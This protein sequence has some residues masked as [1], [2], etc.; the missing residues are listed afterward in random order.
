VAK[1][2]AKK[3]RVAVI[4]NE[5]YLEDD[6]GRT[7][8]WLTTTKPEGQPEL[9]FYDEEHRDRC[10]LYLNSASGDARLAFIGPDGQGQF[11]LGMGPD[12]RC[13]VEVNDANGR[14]AAII[15]VHPDGSRSLQLFD[16]TQKSVLIKHW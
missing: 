9:H 3:K 7:R 15:A 14:L 6:L 12:G 10:V 8:A 4:A 2:K 1:A 16:Y 11:G 5:F 13:G